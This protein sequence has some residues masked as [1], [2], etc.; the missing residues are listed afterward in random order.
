MAKK[1]VKKSKK[2]KRTGSKKT[3]A[4]KSA[5]KTSSVK[6][7][8]VK[9]WHIFRFKQR[10][11]LPDDVRYKRVSPLAFTRDF[12]GSGQ[13]DEAISYHQQ[14]LFLRSMENYLELK[15]AFHELKGIAANRSRC[16]RGYLLDEVYRPA[17]DEKISQWLG[18]S[19]KDAKRILKSLE[20]V[21]LIDRVEVPEFDP[22][23][24]EPPTDDSDISGRARKS[25]GSFKKNDKG[26]GKGK[27]KKK[28]AIGNGKN[29]SNKKTTSVKPQPAEAEGK[30][31]N[32][33]QGKSVT[34]GKGEKKGSV[35]KKATTGRGGGVGREAETPSSPTT[36]PP[37]PFMPTETDAGGESGSFET[38]PSSD[39][40]AVA[41]R[42]DSLY[43]GS[44][45][46]FAE[47]IFKAIQTPCQMDSPQGSR[48]LAAFASAWQR[49]HLAKL[50]PS[51]LDALWQRSV[52]EAAR[53]GRKRKRTKFK[54]S[55]EAAW[56]WVFQ[57]LLT[58]AVEGKDTNET[59]CKAL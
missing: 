51:R 24:N 17:S 35:E 20:Q 34:Q 22:T 45:Q 50:R 28:T 9:V 46:Q 16:Y 30:D 6:K 15:G 5:K 1:A 11:E 8:V 55:A 39:L 40:A 19:V 21:I 58:S 38:L 7:R 32:Q 12:V 59:N 27:G 43:Q 25:S 36:A 26:K 29:K 23:V 56:M 33:S 42:F 44:A 52:K 10:F 3:P 48:E 4:K 57:Q 54:K 49:A 2:K 37:L 41:E 47:E 14:M 18:V 31:M 53:I 13:D